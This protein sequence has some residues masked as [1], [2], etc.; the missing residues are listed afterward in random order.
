MLLRDKELPIWANS[1]TDIAAPNRLIPRSA[2]DAPKCTLSNTDKDD[3]TLATPTND[4][5]APS[6][7]N[8]RSDNDAPKQ[9][10]CKTDN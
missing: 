10:T 8:A 1:T 9:A 5:E 4:R 6:R 7:E 3:P 2:S